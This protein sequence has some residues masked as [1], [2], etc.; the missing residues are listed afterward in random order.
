[1]SATAAFLAVATVIAL[2]QLFLSSA[3]VQAAGAD[4]SP[5]SCPGGTSSG[6]SSSNTC[7]ILHN[8]QLL[9]ER[10]YPANVYRGDSRNP[11]EIFTGG[12]RSRGSNNDLVSHVQ[13]D[14]NYNSN[15]V[16]TS[17]TLSVA[18]TFARSQGMVSLSNLAA[19][20]NCTPGGR[21]F[22]LAI[23]IIGGFL[24][25]FCENGNVTADTFVYVI[26]PR[27]ARTAVYVPDQIRNNVNLYNHYRS[28]D[29][30]AY[31]HEIPNYAIV[32]VRVYTLTARAYRGTLELQAQPPLVYS[33]FLSNPNHLWN[34]IGSYDPQHDSAAHW[35]GNSALNIPPSTVVDGV[36]RRQGCITFDRCQGGG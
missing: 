8:N 19:Q 32:G 24:S 2:F 14:R 6:S 9:S 34:R 29:E 11:Y 36:V 16:S 27:W 33:R 25:E 22:Y 28:Q 15:Y 3:P 20:S 17:G 12:F 26:D 7:P 13:G 5:A 18:E 10:P 4:P 23:P 30:W 1:M 21:R 35:N 31:V